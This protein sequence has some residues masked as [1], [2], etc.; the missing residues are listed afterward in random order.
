MAKELEKLNEFFDV[1]FFNLDMWIK[2]IRSYINVAEA[3][4]SKKQYC[5][6]VKYGQKAVE[7]Y[8]KVLL[9]IK[10]NKILK[11]DDI[12]IL[13]YGFSKKSKLE[14]SKYQ[15]LDKISKLYEIMGISYKNIAE[16]HLKNNQLDDCFEMSKNAL[17]FNPKNVMVNYTLA[18]LLN[19]YGAKAESIDSYETV[20]DIDK[21]Y[22]YGRKVLGDLYGS[23]EIKNLDKSIENYSM[24][25]EK[26]SGNEQSWA[27]CAY[28]YFALGYQDKCN[29]AALKTLEY[30]PAN[31]SALSS[32]MLNLLQ[33]DGYTQKQ[34]KDISEDILEKTI[35]K[36]NINKNSYSFE[37]VNIDENRK[38][39]IGYLSSDFRNHVVSNFFLPIIKN[40]DQSKFD[41]NLY[42]TIN[43]EDSITEVYKQHASNFINC[44]GMTLKEIA[45]K[46]YNDKIDIMIDLNMYTGN[47]KM[48]A[49]AY[50]PAP[51]QCVYMGYPNTSGM[52]TIDYI[53]SD[54][55]TILETEQN[56]YTE[57]PAYIDAGYEIYNFNQNNIPEITSMPYDTNKYITIGIFNKPGKITDKIIGVWSKILLHN[58]KTKILFQYATNYTDKKRESF[59]KAFKKYGINKDRIIFVENKN[60]HFQNMLLA[61]IALDTFP[62]SG[63]GTTMDCLIM[64]LPIVCM[65]GFNSSSRSTSRI[66]KSIDE[67]WFIADSFEEY[68]QKATCLIEHPNKIRDFRFG[69][70]NK[71]KNSKLSDYSG[72][73]KSLE[74]TYIKMW[75]KYCAKRKS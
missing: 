68:I 13:E 19:S 23:K 67:K 3:F 45:D 75:T 60:T 11:P 25:H 4:Y 15:S 16:E 17:L 39:K 7:A 5:D 38:I 6:T 62:Y 41:I 8:N 46:I 49:L 71:I 12:E 31:N 24:Y 59:Y 27:N 52:D 65:R 63:T 9:F 34:I 30:N 57:T 48:Y 51:I 32:Y 35:K 66:L 20:C 70:R 47:S 61:D 18:K 22:T 14:N 73:T 64:G 26:V 36:L 43:T 37:N 72:F 74:N 2:I 58:K 54:R 1:D 33:M 28:H 42:M 55:N 29:E 44:A 53:L 69:I 56:L 10:E 21:N 40:H 50:K